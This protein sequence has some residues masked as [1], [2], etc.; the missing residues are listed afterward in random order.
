[1]ISLLT[2][3]LVEDSETFTLTL[4]NPSAGQVGDLN[5]SVV[6]INNIGIYDYM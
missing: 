6:T 2:D 3:G 5:S 1:M 4:E